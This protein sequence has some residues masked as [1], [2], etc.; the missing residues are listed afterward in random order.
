MAPRKNLIHSRYSV[1]LC[2]FKRS[3]VS[4]FPLISVNSSNTAILVFSVTSSASV[5]SNFQSART[6]TCAGVDWKCPRADARNGFFGLK[7]I[8]FEPQTAIHTRFH[9]TRKKQRKKVSKIPTEL[10]PIRKR[11]RKSQKITD[12]NFFK[13]YGESIENDPDGPRFFVPPGPASQ[14]VGKEWRGFSGSCRRTRSPGRCA[15]SVLTMSV[16]KWIPARKKNEKL[17]RISNKISSHA[18]KSRNSRC[19]GKTETMGRSVWTINHFK[20]DRS[21]NLPR[22]GS[23]SINQSINQPIHRPI[24]RV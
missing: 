22:P 5:V 3:T 19:N 4:L 24:I 20:T 8:R 13:T 21:I 1:T 12:E 11:K 10:L 15:V 18:M 14:S 16:E 23:T 7:M 17:F 2:V 9:P 6:K